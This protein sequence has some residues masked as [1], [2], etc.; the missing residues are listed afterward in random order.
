[1]RNHLS[2]E[3]FWTLEWY[4]LINTTRGASLATETVKHL[5]VMQETWFQSLGWVD[6]LEEEMATHSSIRSWRIPGT[7]ERGRPQSMGLQKSRT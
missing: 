1:M 4:C 6:P 5:P 2:F 3:H 7:E